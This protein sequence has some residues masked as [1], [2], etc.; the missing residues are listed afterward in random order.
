MI[1]IEKL[2]NYIPGISKAGLIDSFIGE[3]NPNHYM[4]WFNKNL[5][6]CFGSTVTRLA[7]KNNIALGHFHGH[8]GVKPMEAILESVKETPIVY[9]IDDAS[10]AEIPHRIQI[11]LLESCNLLIHDYIEGGSFINSNLLRI[12]QQLNVVPKNLMIHTSG[13]NFKQFNHPNVT[14]IPHTPMFGFFVPSTQKEW[15]D[16]GIDAIE[17]YYCADHRNNKEFDHHALILNRK[18]REVRVR[19][20]AQLHK[21]GILDDCK[22]TLAWSNGEADMFNNARSVEGNMERALANDTELFKT[23]F[24]DRIDQLPRQESEIQSNDIGD[25]CEIYLDWCKSKW[26]VSCEVFTVRD[27]DQYI[28]RQGFVTEKT[29]KLLMLGLPVLIVGAPGVGKSLNDAGFFVPDFGWD[30]MYGN[31]RADVVSE[32]LINDVKKQLDTSQYRD[33]CLQNVHTLMT[34]DHMSNLLINS[35]KEVFVR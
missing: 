31:D 5:K 35:L 22:W 15:W 2:N 8:K 12:I 20:L 21:A 16:K 10:F 4:S 18:P 30:N 9:E 11:K 23:F 25:C 3:V 27:L 28:N 7:K 13:F 17:P 34:P 33:K 32:F 19:M 24:K 29:F 26:G 6:H 14:V 1:Y